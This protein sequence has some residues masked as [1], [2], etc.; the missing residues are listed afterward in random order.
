MTEMKLHLSVYL[1][2]QGYDFFSKEQV[3]T[4][5]AVYLNVD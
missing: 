5:T 4:S 1:T 3:A 2:V